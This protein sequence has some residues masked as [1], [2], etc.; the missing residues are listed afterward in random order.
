MVRVKICGITGLADAE[1]AVEAGADALGFVFAESPRRI[2]AS[3][4][5]AIISKLP[6]FVQ[7]VG[8]FANQSAEEIL[9]IMK[10]SGA[11]YAQLCGE[12]PDVRVLS[13]GLGCGRIIRALR[14]R[15]D[16]DIE[17]AMEEC[18]GCSCAAFL[19]D[20]HVEGMMGGTGHTID[21]SLAARAGV[22]GRPIILA[23]GLTPE[24]VEE[25]VAAARPYAVDVSSGVEESPGKKDHAKI[26]EFIK[27]AKKH[28]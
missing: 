16:E 20:A 8:V 11:R 4:A 7:T 1:A 14:I 23:G 27:N 24:N 10:V 22:L 3:A 5:A 21:W 19:L 9:E 15:S 18:P 17:A 26:G 2:D 13:G 12:L 6:P 25:A 28:L